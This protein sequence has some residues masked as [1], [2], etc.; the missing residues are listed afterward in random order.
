MEFTYSL[1]RRPSLVL[2]TVCALA[3]DRVVL[4]GNEREGRFTGDFEGTYA[5]AP[6]HASITI[7]RKPFFVSWNDIAVGL[8]RLVS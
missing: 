3:E 1:R 4:S 2:E 7:T 5:F 8:G 6:N